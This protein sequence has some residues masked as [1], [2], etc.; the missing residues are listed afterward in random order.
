MKLLPGHVL[1]NAHLFSI[2]FVCLFAAKITPYLFVFV[3]N[4]IYHLK[5][6]SMLDAI[7]LQNFEIH[8]YIVIYKH[9]NPP[10]YS[11]IQALEPTII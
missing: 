2:F 10:L 11:N 5:A 1:N 7:K 9:W 3:S 8:H 4:F 6:L